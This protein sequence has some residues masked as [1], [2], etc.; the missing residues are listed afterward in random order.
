MWKC[1]SGD[2][3]GGLDEV[4]RSIVLTI[5]SQRCLKT[6]S[7]VFLVA[8]LLAIWSG[9]VVVGLNNARLR[10]AAARCLRPTAPVV[11]TVLFARDPKRQDGKESDQDGSTVTTVSASA[12]TS[13]ST[14]PGG[15]EGMVSIPYGGLAGYK[16][17]SL[18]TDPVPLFDPLKD[19]SDLP[20]EVGSP[21]NTAAMM[22][23]IEERVAQL[24]QTPEWAE[25]QQ[26]EFGKNPL[27]KIPFWQGLWMHAKAAQRDDN[28]D[29]LPLVIFNSAFIIAFLAVYLSIINSGLK[30]ALDWY[31]RTDFDFDLI[32]PFLHLHSN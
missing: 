18:F 4:L 32:F 26:S 5:V 23:R 10:P 17:G 29:E 19:T 3:Q 8:L 7:S 30:S 31:I 24:K 11:S 25:I 13:A 27:E 1:E 16:Q 28:P 14:L 12:S 6:M 21:E 20:G 22:R 9:S 15:E 2:L